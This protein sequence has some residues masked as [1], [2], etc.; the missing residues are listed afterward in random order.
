MTFFGF[1]LLNL[2]FVMKLEILAREK[3]ALQR[4]RGG[5]CGDR[6]LI[7]S[8]PCRLVSKFLKTVINQYYT[9]QVICLSNVV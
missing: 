2:Y 4:G 5:S 7:R 6:M 9:R 3:I 1:V 8:L